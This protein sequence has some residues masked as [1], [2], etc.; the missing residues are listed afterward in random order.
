VGELARGQNLAGLGE[1][2]HAGG[3]VDAVAE[4]LAAAED[5]LAQVQAR[6]DG[7]L[8]VVRERDVLV[9]TPRRE[10]KRR[11]RRS[12]V[13]GARAI[14]RRLP[15]PGGVNAPQFLTLEGVL[16]IHAD[17]I[18]RYGGSAG[19]RDLGLLQSALAMPETTFDGEYLHP[20]P[21]EMAAAYLFHLARNH[22]F[23][24]GNKRTA[25][26]C[27]L[28]F[29]GLNGCRLDADPAA[30]H[31]LVDGVAAGGVDKAQTAVF[32]RQNCLQRRG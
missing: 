26:M 16:G 17:L 31:A 9:V 6:A 13:R 24:D 32:S 29:L 5:G 11:R 28:V 25:L 1:R 14:R 4:D 3:D 30:L 20:S 18:R 22:P 23:V 19:L 10:R 2:A 21:F 15:S 7:E 12:R 8:R 27:A